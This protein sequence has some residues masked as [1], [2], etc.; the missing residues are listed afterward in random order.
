MFVDMMEA[1][2]LARSTCKSFRAP[3]FT[4]LIVPYNSIQ[5]NYMIIMQWLVGWF[6]DE[7]KKGVCIGKKGALWPHITYK[8]EGL[9]PQRV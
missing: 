2:Q 1:H 5:Y 7:G 8:E 4:L 9:L 3:P 6:M